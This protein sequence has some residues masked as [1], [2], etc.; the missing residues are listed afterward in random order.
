MR[1][2]VEAAE[3]CVETNSQRFESA[4]CDD[5]ISGA[6]DASNDFDSCEGAIVPLR[7]E[8]ETCGTVEEDEDGL[9]SGYR[10]MVIA[11]TVFI[12]PM[13][14]MTVRRRFVC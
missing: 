8:G 10:I 9:A 14:R 3:A 12:V 6:F 2:D 11:Q 7:G 4:S 13:A 5:F 1:I